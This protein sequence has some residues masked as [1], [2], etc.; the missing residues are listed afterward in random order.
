[1]SF[2]EVNNVRCTGKARGPSL[3]EIFN[4]QMDSAI[5]DMATSMLNMM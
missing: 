5:S 4:I 1:M 2:P 3:E